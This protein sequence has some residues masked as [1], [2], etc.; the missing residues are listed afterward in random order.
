MPVTGLGP[1]LILYDL[2]STGL[3]LQRPNF[4]NKITFTVQGIKTSKYIWGGHSLTHNNS[5][6]TKVQREVNG[7]KI[8]YI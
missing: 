7:V 2:I 5:N 3:H 8:L 4:Q 1:T 6:G